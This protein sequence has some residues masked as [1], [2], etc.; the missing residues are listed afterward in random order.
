M[1][2]KE[3]KEKQEKII[4]NIVN[5]NLSIAFKLIPEIAYASRKGDLITK[6]EELESTY[7]NILKYS[8]GDVKDPDRVKVYGTLR[9]NLLELTDDIVGAIFENS[10]EWFASIKKDDSE[11][12][13]LGEKEKY[14]LID[15]MTI[16]KEFSSLLKEVENNEKSNLESD[17][18]YI[19][20]LSKVFDILWLTNNYSGGEKIL[21]NKLFETKHIPWHD[22][23]LIVSAIFLSALR[24]FDITKFDVLF[25]IY[26]KEE[27][28][29]SHRA[30]VSIF[31][32]IL[33]YESRLKL[34]SEVENRF[35]SI[36]D[37]KKFSKQ[38]EQITLQFIRAQETE[39]VT[40]KI[41]KEIIPEVMKI[42]PEIEEKLKLNDLL[43][44]ENLE[45]D[46]N[47]DWQEF[48]N[49][50]PE[51]YKKL[52][53][54]SM[55]QMDGSD[56]FMGAFS[57]LKRFGFFDKLSNWFLPYYKEHAEIKKSIS[58]VAENFNWDSF[59]TGIEEAPVLCNSDKYSFCFNIG[60]MPEVQKSMMLDYFN[61][62]L[63]QMKEV[64]Q[65]ENKHNHIAKDKTVYTQY[66][67]DLYRFFYLHPKKEH[68]KNIFK[69]NIDINKSYYFNLILNEESI[70]Q[71]GEFYFKKNYFNE[72]KNI[73]IHLNEKKASYELIEK[74]GFCFQKLGDYL[75]AIDYYKQAEI[76]ETNK[77]WLQKKLGLCY[78]RL[79]QYDSSIEY[80]KLVEK[81]EPE[82]LEIQA[83]LGQLHIDKDDFETALKYYFKVEY[84]KPD[85]AKVQ[86][87]IG[88][89]S[90]M[91]GKNEQALRYFKKVVEN[92]GLRSDYINLGHCY[93]V[94]G[95]LS[96]AIE[97]YR[98]A[99]K[100]SGNIQWFTETMKKDSHAL[101]HYGIEELDVQLMADYMTIDL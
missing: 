19:H 9:R 83:Y 87:P 45:E 28:E 93:W 44:K 70:R 81:E 35:K 29:V 78:M 13:R 91:L 24:H 51:V 56:V 82:N 22:K 100:Q 20:S 17:S 1:E 76:F 15:E 73:F 4:T 64:A 72:A 79:E 39:Q 62:E 89:C 90:F 6:Q 14:A 33:V 43:N 42:K 63:Q 53:E 52:E 61:L 96:E 55:M 67:Q 75:K 8:F 49:E 95:N 77:S 12:F 84:L 46:K 98:K 94:S 21:S 88:W 99:V 41:Q 80:Y 26:D 54:F 30:L 48:F 16:E 85:L 58:G 10:D 18:K 97:N 47:P 60:F 66:I 34:Y 23:S 86:R 37:S 101:Q 36:V 68:F 27:P 5:G 31:I 92:E 50:T 71:I 69:I 65:E 11:F 59:F 38:W 2:L 40:N 3:V 25:N 57:L 7:K 74:I 32:L